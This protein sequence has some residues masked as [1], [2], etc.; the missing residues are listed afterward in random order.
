MRVSQNA[1][2]KHYVLRVGSS[3]PDGL[4][5]AYP[6]RTVVVDALQHPASGN[7]WRS[8]S[9]TD[10]CVVTSILAPSPARHPP[11]IHSSSVSMSANA[12]LCLPKGPRRKASRALQLRPG[13][14]VPTTM[15]LRQ[16]FPG[17]AFIRTARLP[18]DE[19][20][21]RSVDHVIAAYVCVH[22]H[23]N[24]ASARHLVGHRI[25]RRSDAFTGL[26]AVKAYESF[27]RRLC[28]SGAG[29]VMYAT[30]T[31]VT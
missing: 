23:T 22:F 21:S 11:C 12:V 7:R 28:Q 17:C 6:N 4:S 31:T 18:I 10:V 2:G 20:S 19:S 30:T 14:E 26:T 8:L 16:R 24:L 29:C 13:S 9:Q 1:P 3:P 5:A 15:F 25:R 27:Q